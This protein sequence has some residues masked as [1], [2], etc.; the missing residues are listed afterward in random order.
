MPTLNIRGIDAELLQSLRVIA[1]NNRMTVKA[2]IVETLRARTRQDEID[3]HRIENQVAQDW[4]KKNGL[5]QAKGLPPIEVLPA[6]VIE[7]V[8][9]EPIKHEMVMR[10][11]KTC[12]HGFQT[13]VPCGYPRV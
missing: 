11:V 1:V 2:L 4:W 8:E 5:P 10:P 13:C 6:E 9:V 12:K 7:I 3:A